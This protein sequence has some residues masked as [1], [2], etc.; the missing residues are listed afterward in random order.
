MNSCIS[1]NLKVMGIS[2]LTP[3]QL[4]VF[5]PI[6][7]G[8][9]TLFTSPTGTGNSL[10]LTDRK[11]FGISLTDNIKVYVRSVRSSKK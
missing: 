3:M 7:S 1:A 6:Y 10:I 11:D 5:Q 2:V 8:H 9:D 4:K